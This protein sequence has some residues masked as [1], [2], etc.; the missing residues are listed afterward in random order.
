MDTDSLAAIATGRAESLFLEDLEC[1]RAGIADRIRGA[2]V[3][4]VGGG[5]SIGR[6]TIHALIPF[7]PREVVIV[8]ISENS[9][10]ELTRDLR[11][12]WKSATLPQIVCLPIDF[13]TAIFRRVLREGRPFDLVLNF[14]AIKHVRSEKNTCSTLQMIETNVLKVA[15]ALVWLRESQFRGRFFS[16]STDKAANPVNLMGATKRIMERVMFS[17]SEPH[18][19]RSDV[20]SARFA[21]VAFSDGSL[22]FGWTQRVAKRQPIPCPQGA[23][24]YFVSLEEAGQI[25]LLAGA[26]G[27][28]QKILIP[29]LDAG[30]DLVELTQ[31]ARRFI[32]H[33]GFLPKE[34]LDE[35]EAKA[36]VARDV[37]AGKYP[38]LLTPLD[39]DG[40]KSFEEFVAEGEKLES[41]GLPHLRAVVPIPSEPAPLLAFIAAFERAVG[42]SGVPTSKQ[43]VIAAVSSVVPEFRHAHTG[44][45]LDDRF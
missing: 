27:D 17:L 33:L 39:T 13:G 35:E 24:R 20:T 28:S 16:V 7:A 42:D 45:S 25:C 15:Q 18:D 14:A 41:I 5:G 29:T 9:L 26:V 3:L 2:R 11:G 8:D 10:V 44:R 6:A 38:L 4:V 37:E 21:N 40:E 1:C 43:D 32:A 34:Y 31:V 23:G 30:R 36:N 19:S 12:T 22:L